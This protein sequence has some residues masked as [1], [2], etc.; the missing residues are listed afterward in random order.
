MF[1]VGSHWSSR[2]A[3]ETGTGRVARSGGSQG[4]TGRDFLSEILEIN[5]QSM[6]HKRSSAGL[7]IRKF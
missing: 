3:G 6:W 7:Y 5:V 1:P 2:S 4:R